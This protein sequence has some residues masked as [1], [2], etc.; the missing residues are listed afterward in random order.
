MWGIVAKIANAANLP[1]GPLSEFLN[2]SITL[3]TST[4]ATSKIMVT[5]TRRVFV[6]ELVPIFPKT[7][8]DGLFSRPLLPCEV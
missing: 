1:A 5:G 7:Q 4:S 8:R 3:G 2:L 6:F